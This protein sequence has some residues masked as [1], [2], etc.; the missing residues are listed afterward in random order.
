[1]R[2][3]FSET[4]NAPLQAIKIKPKGV[5]AEVFVW[6]ADGRHYAK[7]YAGKAGKPSFYYTFRTEREREAHVTKWIANRLAVQGYKDEQRRTRREFRHSLAVGDIL[8]Y[9]WGYDQTNIDFFQVVALRGEKQIIIRK[10]RSESA[11]EHGQMSDYCLPLPGSF[12]GTEIV[13]TPQIGNYV[14]MS[15]GGASKWDGRPRYRSWYA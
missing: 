2:N 12:C 13:K 4:R 1:M 7:A 3:R 8:V 5:E 6:D 15:N 14:P 10:I 9:S 11:G